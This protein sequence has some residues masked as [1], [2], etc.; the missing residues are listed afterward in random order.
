MNQDLWWWPS[1]LVRKIKHGAI[2]ERGGGV[3]TLYHPP[4]LA[5]QLTLSQLGG[6]HITI[7]P[8]P[9]PDFQTFLL[10]CL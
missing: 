3:G 7:R 9:P 8:Y 2:E 4:T 1:D 6:Q 10:P 5:N